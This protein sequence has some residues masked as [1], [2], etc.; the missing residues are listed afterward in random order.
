[1]LDLTLGPNNLTVRIQIIAMSN[2]NVFLHCLEN[3]TMV[4]RYA[5]FPIDVIVI[6]EDF[7]ALNIWV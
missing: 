7:A 6:W 3:A 4:V 1:M 5:V 2:D